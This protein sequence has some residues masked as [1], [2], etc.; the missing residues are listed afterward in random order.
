MTTLAFDLAGR[1]KW[2]A[3][4]V[5]AALLTYAICS[6][7]EVPDLWWWVIFVFVATLVILLIVLVVN[8][9]RRR[10]QERGFESALASGGA[11][12][13]DQKAEID[14][15]R[16]RWKES[17]ATLRKSGAGGGGR[18]ALAALPW[19]VIIGAPASGKSTLLRHSGLDFPIGD[20]ALRGLQGTRNCDWWFSSVG[21]FLDTAGRFMSDE[22]AKE[23]AEFLG[24][25]RRQRAASPIN[26]VIVAVPAT[27]L[28][29]Y[30]DEGEEAFLQRVDTDA[31]RIRTRLDELIDHLGIN[32]PVWVVLTKVDLLGG[33]V[34]FFGKLDAQA[35]ARLMGWTE[36]PADR[37]DRARFEAQFDGMV[38][39]LVDIR[40]QVMGAAP[41]RQRHQAFGFPDE[42]ADLRDP[43]ARLLQRMFEPN[44]FQETPFFR[45]LFVTS[46]TQEGAPLQQAVAAIRER[47]GDTAP[48]FE[49]ES[50]IKQ[51]YFVEDL[52]R[53]RV[54]GDRA[55]T[56]TTQTE[57]DRGR[58]RRLGKN[59][60]GCSFPVLA[61]IAIAGMWKRADADLGT[62]RATVKDVGALPPVDAAAALCRVRT[63]LKSNKFDHLGL[64]AHWM[65]KRDAW[66][67][68]EYLYAAGVL[69]PLLAATGRR[70]TETPSPN[71]L[72]GPIADFQAFRAVAATLRKISAGPAP[73]APAAGGTEGGEAPAPA[74]AA[75]ATG[76]AAPAKPPAEGGCD[77]RSMAGEEALSPRSCEPPAIAMEPADTQALDRAWELCSAAGMAS[78]DA[79]EG[80]TG[81]ERFQANLVALVARHGFGPMDYCVEEGGRRVVVAYDPVAEEVAAVEGAFRAAVKNYLGRVA[82]ELGRYEE[83]RGAVTRLLDGRTEALR[84]RCRE[85]SGALA[86]DRM[87]L[88]ETFALVEAL[89]KAATTT[90]EGDAGA[91]PEKGLPFLDAAN[92]GLAA[93]DKSGLL[94]PE[95]L[96][97]LLAEAG[98][99]RARLTGVATLQASGDELSSRGGA[100]AAVTAALR[101]LLSME[102]D[103]PAADEFELRTDVRAAR[104]HIDNRVKAAHEDWSRR[105]RP[106]LA[107]VAGAKDGKWESL[108]REDAEAW[109]TI[110]TLHRAL[111]R[112]V[113]YARLLDASQRVHYATLVDRALQAPREGRGTPDVQYSLA[114]LKRLVQ[115]IG[116][117]PAALDAAQPPATRR[118]RDAARAIA[119]DRGVRVAVTDARNA[120]VQFFGTSVERYQGK[121]VDAAGQYLER[122][123]LRDGAG[124]RSY[125]A[126]VSK[127]LGGDWLAGD[128]NPTAVVAEARPLVTELQQ[129]FRFFSDDGG[130]RRVRV[131]LQ[132][133]R[134]CEKDVDRA[135]ANPGSS[136]RLQEKLVTLKDGLGADRDKSWEGIGH[137]IAE[138]GLPQGLDPV[139]AGLRL[140]TRQLVDSIE[141]NLAQYFNGR[142]KAVRNAMVRST[143]AGGTAAADGPVPEAFTEF[144]EEL[145]EWFG[146]DLTDSVGSLHATEP[147]QRYAGGLDRWSRERNDLDSRGIGIRFIPRSVPNVQGFPGM[148]IAYSRRGGAATESTYEPG[149]ASSPLSI[150]W[151]PSDDGRLE[152]N[153]LPATGTTGT[154]IQFAV[155]EGSD[156]IP[157]AVRGARESGAAGV[158]LW[159]SQSAQY[160]GQ[161][162]GIEIECNSADLDRLRRYGQGDGPGEPPGAGEC[163]E[164]GK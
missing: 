60:V 161:A 43:L 40:P 31:R 99:D 8:W 133:M 57:L 93:L 45:G 149:K 4:P 115:E 75:P 85:V 77:P 46:G 41:L 155:W 66:N 80:R 28:F 20:A 39:R 64:N 126:A 100:M 146:V 62:A 25:V 63:A 9:A 34:E 5:A 10:S 70:I 3:I 38:D 33:F 79:R 104:T 108:S 142:W 1:V 12:R 137:L 6:L 148:R 111:A 163:V 65:V 109:G 27:D 138:A 147:F 23:W 36:A 61:L 131:S 140:A 129:S 24:L 15:L 122:H 14:A 117:V 110:E 83:D 96:A 86:R 141:K 160:A 48:E 74:P 164:G 54:V 97:A 2:F 22:S 135:A 67:E 125:E 136:R 55:M 59:L 81:R 132:E 157:R 71:D 102:R 162:A 156:C 113:L 152:I 128:P 17:L 16:K 159:S 120:W 153:L 37:F 18:R 29:P 26:G 106:S 116:D 49:P 68:E 73:A 52:I 130:A 82:Q 56:W 134:D 101:G 13:V 145:Q 98:L 119:V 143:Q 51:A 112:D 42:V 21:I 89:V 123:W 76:P 11:G 53:E 151:K 84:T 92:N 87:E 105:I 90:A 91:T 121:D 47:F 58:L 114:S 35:R 44:V 32:F 69:R 50:V 78:T 124:A 30:D 94:A 139:D 150:V 103:F 88:S 95:A 127:A 19:Y 7:L 72:A 118:L 158:Y 107:A 154:A 144:R